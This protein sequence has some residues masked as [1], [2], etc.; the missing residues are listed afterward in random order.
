MPEQKS[1]GD[2]NKWKETQARLDYVL[3]AYH[4]G[5]EIKVSRQRAAQVANGPACA[6]KIN[7]IRGQGIP[8]LKERSHQR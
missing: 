5:K 2:I 8:D 4:Q 6:Y 7:L 1:N 3:I